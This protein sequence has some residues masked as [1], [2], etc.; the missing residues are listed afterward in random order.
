M[1]VVTACSSRFHIFDQAVQL[2]RFGI[3][4]KIINANPAFHA[5][6]W[7]IEKSRIISSTHYGLAQRVINRMPHF[8]YS[9]LN[10]YFHRSYSSFIS[11]NIPI[12]TNVFIGLSSLSLDA[13]K[14]CK[15][16]GITSIVDHGS[17][18]LRFERE[19]ILRAYE[20]IGLKSGPELA[21]EWIIQREQDEFQAADKVVVLSQLAKS[22]LIAEGVSEEN[23]FVNQCGV[24]TRK[25]FPVTKLDDI[26]RIVFCGG[27]SVRKGVHLLVRAF[28]NLNL[29]RSELLLVGGF[30]DRSYVDKVLRDLPANIRYLGVTS[31]ESLHRIYG[32]GT[33]FV[34]PS[35]ADGFGMVVSQALASGLPVICSDAVGASDIIDHGRNGFVFKS[36]DVADLE[37]YILR[38]YEDVD[39]VEWSAGQAVSSVRGQQDWDAYGDRM[40]NFLLSVQ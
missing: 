24:D 8:L 11:K 13:I 31:Q 28:K 22:T 23:I 29:P 27:I 4:Y 7:G 18:H 37:N 10:H 26:F 21:E 14:R 35:V 40:H 20:N 25:F 36:Q 2:Q 33:I 3:L 5:N 6:N 12:D 38:Y 39:F 15:S 17:L 19:A 1:K 16:M 30:Q 9:R 34:L 32:R